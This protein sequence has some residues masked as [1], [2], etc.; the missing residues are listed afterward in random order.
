MKI[1]NTGKPALAESNQAAPV[2][3][4]GVTV[5]PSAASVVI[6]QNSLI[7]VTVLPDGATN[8]SFSAASSDTT[9]ATITVSGNNVTAKGVKAGV[10]QIII[11][12]N[13]GQKLA[14]CN[15]TVTAA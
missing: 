4:T 14:I 1:T 8:G 11:M 5:T 13:E 9:V 3:V 6:G 10:A 2:P 7:G 12:T 15:L